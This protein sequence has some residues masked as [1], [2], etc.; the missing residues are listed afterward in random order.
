[1]KKIGT[2]CCLLFCSCVVFGQEESVKGSA[3]LNELVLKEKNG[4]AFM[5]AEKPAIF[6]FG[7]NNLNSRIIKNFRMR[8]ISSNADKE[9]CEIT[10]V[11]DKEGLMTEVKTSGS[12]ESFNNEAEKAILKIKDR[13]IPAEMNGEKV[14]YRFRIPLTI[15]FNNK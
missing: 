10:F 5:D 12:N 1:V 3:N 11:I 9:S 4:K 14:R 13:W 15:T 2:L 8:K 6:P 7:T